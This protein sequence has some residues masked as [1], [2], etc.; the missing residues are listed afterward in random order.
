MKRNVL[1][2]VVLFAFGIWALTLSAAEAKVTIKLA[3]VDQPGRFETCMGAMSNTFKDVVEAMS[4]G[5]IQVSIYPAGQLGNMREMMESTQ[6]GST[7]IVMCYTAVAT[8]FSPKI[9]AVQIPFIFPTAAHAWRTL[10]GWWGKELAGEFMKDTGLRVLAWGEGFG[11]RVI[12]NNKKP[13]KKPADLKGL[14]IRV[15]ESKGLFALVQALGAAPVTIT[16]TEL[17][18]ALQTGVADGCEPELGAGA[19]I[20]L[21][22]VTKHITLTN[23]GY[24]IHGMFVN[25]K[26]FQ[27][28]SEKDKKIIIEG[29]RIAEIASRGISQ[30]LVGANTQVYLNK[31]VQIYAPT[32]EE[33][34]EIIKI[35]QP[36]YIKAVEKDMGKEWIEKTFKATKEAT[37]AMDAEAGKMMKK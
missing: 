34:A 13:V 1:S 29:A 21:H 19:P 25:D 22:E 32:P 16:W 28:Q 17:Y 5:E 9:A 8:T 2:A 23:H 11:F 35:G 18:T 14:K 31:G 12:W 4:S 20:K 37:A 6:M 7:Q 3:H 36:A 27:Q 24:N 15:P 30:N 33:M 26:W 10:D